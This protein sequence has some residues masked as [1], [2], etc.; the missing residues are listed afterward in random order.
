MK[1]LLFGVH[2]W[3]EGDGVISAAF[4]VSDTTSCGT[5]SSGFQMKI[6]TAGSAFEVISLK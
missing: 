4:Y 3:F 5:A 6:E 1:A 2:Q